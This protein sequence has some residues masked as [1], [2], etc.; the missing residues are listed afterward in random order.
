MNDKYYNIYMYTEIGIPTEP[1]LSN[2]KPEKISKSEFV[3]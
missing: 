3:I 2:Q 1:E